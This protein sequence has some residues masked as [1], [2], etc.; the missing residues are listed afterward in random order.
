VLNYWVRPG[1]RRSSLLD[2]I[3]YC[4]EYCCGDVY[5]NLLHYV[6]PVPCLEKHACEF[7]AIEGYYASSTSILPLETQGRWLLNIRYVNYTIMPDGS[8]VVSAQSLCSGKVHTRNY[9][10]IVG[11]TLAVEDRFF[12]EM[13]VGDTEFRHDSVPVLGMEDARL[14]LGVDGAIRWIGASMEYSRT[15][16]VGQLTGRYDLQAKRLCDIRCAET[17]VEH[18]GDARLRVEK[19]WIPLGVGPSLLRGT[20]DLFVYGWSPFAVGKLGQTVAG[21][22]S[23]ELVTRHETPNFLENYRGS[24]NFVEHRGELLC[25]THVVQYMSPRKYFHQ[26]VRVR[27][28]TLDVVSHSC[29]FYF[30]EN[31]IEFVLGIFLTGDILNVIV[32]RNDRN[33][34][35]VQIAIDGVELFSAR[36]GEIKI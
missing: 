5:Y 6:D 3:N 18:G 32:S 15:G 33:P 25:V 10:A 22:A 20:D 1:D 12:F 16:T 28:D 2:L 11:P 29:P 7:P 31:A 19:N 14:F 23:L 9:A 21:G 26:L 27:P 8:Y 30:F 35:V 17:P 24:S 4:N 13:T 36:M 34:W